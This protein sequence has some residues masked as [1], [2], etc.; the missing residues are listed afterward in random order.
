M[1]HQPTPQSRRLRPA[2]IPAQA[3][4]LSAQ[5]RAAGALEPIPTQL[6]IV[7]QAG[8]RFQLRVLCSLWRKE[9]ATAKQ[10]ERA[11][12]G[13]H[14]DPFGPCNPALLLGDLSDTHCCVLNKYPAFAGHMLIVTRAFEAQDRLLTV[15]DFAALWRGLEGVDGLVFYNGGPQAGASQ[16]HKHLQLLPMPMHPGEP[17]VPLAARF[18]QADVR[19]GVGRVP[20]LPFEH[21]LLHLPAALL[22]DARQAAVASLGGYHRLLAAVGLARRPGDPHQPGPYNLLMTRR[23]MFLVPRREDDWQGCSVNALGFAGSLLARD[24]AELARIRTTGPMALLAHTGRPIE[25][26]GPQGPPG[27]RLGGLAPEL[28]LQRPAEAAAARAPA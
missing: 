15:R 23:W 18:A 7:E 9:R 26:E 8:V 11:A 5:A 10:R 24:D 21:A 14:A 22:G 17:P 16:R 1:P 2:D 28:A 6:E 4:E 3:A 20:G 13:E 19:D 12:R 25:R 27:P